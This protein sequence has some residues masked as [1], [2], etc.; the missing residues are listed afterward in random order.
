LKNN[1]IIEKIIDLF[2]SFRRLRYFLAI[3][4]ADSFN[5]AAD[6]LAISQPSIS[7]QCA[8]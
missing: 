3:A 7:Q 2:D 4:E 8:M 6:H 1:V 5:R